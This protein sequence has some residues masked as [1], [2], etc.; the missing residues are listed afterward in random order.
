MLSL[1]NNLL[2]LFKESQYLELFVP[3][4]EHSLESPGELVKPQIPGFLS[5]EGW[6]GV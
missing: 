3:Q 5:E 6:G 4:L 1:S 2:P